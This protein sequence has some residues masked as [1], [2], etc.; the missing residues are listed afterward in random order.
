M[1][2]IA[3]QAKGLTLKVPPGGSTRPMDGMSRG[4]LF[5]ILMPRLAGSRVLDL[6]AGCGSLG[7]EALS[8]GAES[9]VFV[10][11][12]RDAARL[13][14]DN[15]Q[16]SRLAGGEVLC[17]PCALAARTLAGR[18]ARFS[19]AFYDPPFAASR[20]PESRAALMRELAAAG[21]LLE[22]GGLAVWR[23]ECR[24]YFPE[25]LP[26][27]LEPVDRREYG[28]SLLVFARRRADGAPGDAPPP[29]APAAAAET[30]GDRP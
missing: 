5:N 23:L 25:E 12:S 11:R 13:L 9:C 2:I 17:T 16:R 10:E 27:A 24:N 28:R 18:G 14:E 20:T 22:A 6:Y 8:R 1:R 30:A 19:L 15:L 4:A 29:P 3:G 21:E 26:A 7:L